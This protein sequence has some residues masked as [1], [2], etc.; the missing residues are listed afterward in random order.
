LFLTVSPGGEVYATDVANHRVLHYDPDGRLV[1]SW[2][3]VGAGPGRFS[4]PQGVALDSHGNVDVADFDNVRLQKF[5]PTGRFLAQWPT[6][7]P[8]GPMGVAVDS[9]DNIYVVQHRRHDH[10]VLKFDTGGG[11]LARSGADGSGR[12]EFGPQPVGIGVDGHGTVYVTD[13]SHG[14]LQVFDSAGAYKATWDH[15]GGSS[16]AVL[17]HPDGLA[18]DSKGNVY[19]LDTSSALLQAFDERAQLLATLQA[20]DWPRSINAIAVDQQENLYLAVAA[21]D[22]SSQAGTIQ[23]LRGLLKLPGTAPLTGRGSSVREGILA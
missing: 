11:L 12:G 10:H 17:N 3:G 15:V 18:V 8:A 9:S 1:G 2:G 7:P 23:K 14:V 22:R 13:T 4:R 19:V 20:A 21:N 6:E 5:D 16:T